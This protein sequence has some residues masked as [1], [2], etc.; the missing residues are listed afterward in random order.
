MGAGRSFALL[1]ACAAFLAAQA[2]ASPTALS[3]AASVS[4]YA[5]LSQGEGVELR[6][7]QNR[8]ISRAALARELRA[9]AAAESAPVA[10]K[11]AR[12]LAEFLERLSAPVSRV[13]GGQGAAP[14]HGV[15]A[16][17]AP[18]PPKA[19]IT[20]PAVRL[21]APAAAPRRA[22][23]VGLPSAFFGRAFSVPLRI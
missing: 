13:R 22:D 11:A 6:D 1:A 19:R 20:L 9:G 17:A 21:G 5:A 14:H 2:S 23:P 3:Q 4:P 15:S 16:A 8:P 18:R 12:L 10:T 7:A